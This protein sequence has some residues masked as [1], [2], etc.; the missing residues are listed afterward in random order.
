MPYKSKG[1]LRF[2][3][4]RYRRLIFVPDSNHLVKKGNRECAAFYGDNHTVQDRFIDLDANR[5]GVLVTF[6][7]AFWKDEIARQQL[8]SAVAGRM[9]VEIVAEHNLENIPPPPDVGVLLNDIGLPAE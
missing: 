2:E 4:V 8:A 7:G 6:S 3:S 9:R 5:R 1:T